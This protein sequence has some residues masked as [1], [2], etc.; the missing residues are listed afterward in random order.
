MKKILYA[1]VLLAFIVIITSCG[2]NT[3]YYNLGNKNI[4]YFNYAETNTPIT[5]EINPYSF[6]QEENKWL[7]NRKDIKWSG[8]RASNPQKYY[9]VVVEYREYG[10]HQRYQEFELKDGLMVFEN[11]HQELGNNSKFEFKFH[12]IDKETQDKKTMINYYGIFTFKKSPANPEVNEVTILVN[13]SYTLLNNV[14]E[15]S[16]EDRLTNAQLTEKYNVEYKI[17]Q[18]GNILEIEVENGAVAFTEPG[19]YDVVVKLTAKSSGSNNNSDDNSGASPA[20]TSSGSSESDATS[21]ATGTGDSDGTSGATPGTGNNTQTGY[22]LE[23]RYT[24]KVTEE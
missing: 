5:L 18:N 11:P 24:I 2:I 14:V 22:S 16:G 9:D 7:S 8:A 17:Y 10:S 3:H 12:F 4:Y 23:I 20:S 19:T 21:S 6:L 13:E 15:Y 1:V